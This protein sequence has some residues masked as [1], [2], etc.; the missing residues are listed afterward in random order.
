MPERGRYRCDSMTNVTMGHVLP[1]DLVSR[2]WHAPLRLRPL[3]KE[4]RPSILL[5]PE[6][7]IADMRASEL[8]EAGGIKTRPEQ[9][10]LY[11]LPSHSRPFVVSPRDCTKTQ[12]I[13]WVSV[14][15]HPRPFVAPCM[16]RGYF[17]FL[18]PI[19]FFFNQLTRSKW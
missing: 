8:M 1:R 5:V 4:H 15:G 10:L 3:C 18:L 9:F 7:G 6:R 17:C 12:S 16:R 2:R 19:F 14:G 13:C 11:L